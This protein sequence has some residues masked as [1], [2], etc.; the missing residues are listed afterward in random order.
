[1]TALDEL[2]EATKDSVTAKQRVLSPRGGA[3]RFGPDIARYIGW[4]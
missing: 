4:G 1:M 3:A 2:K